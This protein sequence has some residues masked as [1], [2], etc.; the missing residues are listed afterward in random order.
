MKRVCSCRL[1]LQQV[2]LP[3]RVF[4]ATQ[5]TPWLHQKE[6]YSVL[7]KVSVTQSKIQSGKHNSRKRKNASHLTNNTFSLNWADTS[8]AAAAWACCSSRCMSSDT[9]S[10]VPLQQRKI[11]FSTLVCRPPY[12]FTQFS[13][14]QIDRVREKPDHQPRPQ[15]LSSPRSAPRDGKRDPGNEVAWSHA[16]GLIYSV[17]YKLVFSVKQKKNQYPD[18]SSDNHLGRERR[19]VIL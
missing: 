14:P 8:F 6:N 10:S 3:W 18:G 11:L 9:G 12:R 5:S 2:L 15:G 1:K 19:G 16:W 17:Y 4:N 7:A 13:F